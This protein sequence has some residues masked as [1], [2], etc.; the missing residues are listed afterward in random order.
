MPQQATVL[1]I[2]QHELLG[3]G[4]AARLRSLGTAAA[5]V[6]ADNPDTLAAALE[7]A[8]DLIV[9]ESTNPECLAR[10]ARLSPGSRIVD[11]TASIGRGCPTEA[12]RFDVIL[13]AL[14][15]DP[16]MQAPA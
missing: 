10:I 11:V 13:D 6:R 8:P 14:R 15:P 3:E 4:L 9:V 5:T 2:F 7:C 1:V 12:M 16:P